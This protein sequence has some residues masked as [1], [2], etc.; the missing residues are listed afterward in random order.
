MTVFL[1]RLAMTQRNLDLFQ[2]QMICLFIV[3]EVMGIYYRLDCGMSTPMVHC[4]LE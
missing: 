2:I 1:E 4:F 3:G